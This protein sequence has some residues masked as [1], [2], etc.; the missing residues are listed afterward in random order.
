MPLTFPLS[1]AAWQDLLP[2]AQMRLELDEA[3]QSDET[4]GGE[5][6]A[7]DIG[8]ALWQGELVLAPSTR[9]LSS[10]HQA[11]IAAVRSPG[12]PFHVT[13]LTRPYPAADPAG[14]VLGSFNAF[15]PTVLANSQNGGREIVLSGLHAN[16]VLSP[17]DWLHFDY[18]SSPA[19]RALHQVVTGN[20]ADSFG[21]STDWIEVVPPVRPFTGTPAV[22][23]ARPSCKAVYVP[24]SGA[25]RVVQGY[26]GSGLSLRFRQTLT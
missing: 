10:R 11:L 26:T 9:L 21:D 3:M 20:T 14:T 5:V 18:G 2:V 17:G 12:R 4:G 19:R 6:F 23:L 15:A 22:T 8:A 13:D 25:G 24:G 16:Y 7:A 1:L